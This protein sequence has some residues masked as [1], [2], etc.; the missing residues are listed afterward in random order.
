MIKSR[1]ALDADIPTVHKLL[2]PGIF[3]P[4]R[5]MCA[6]ST[7]EGSITG[8]VLARPVMLCHG[9]TIEAGPTA[10]TQAGQL[11]HYGMGVLKGMGHREM[12]LIVDPGNTRMEAYAEDFG[13][14]RDRPG[15]IYFKE[16]C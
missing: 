3:V 13:A 4:P 10:R 8:V 15:L 6:V 16:I 11:L 7:L 5:D 12:V 2:G 14:T 1:L 9:F